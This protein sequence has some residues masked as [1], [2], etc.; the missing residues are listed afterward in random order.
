MKRVPLVR[1]TPLSPISK[2][3]KIAK[4]EY[5]KLK[6]IYLYSHELCEICMKNKSNQIHHRR[7]RGK[8]LRDVT[9]FMALCQTCHSMVHANPETSYLEGWLIK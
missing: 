4:N 5:M 7:H 1:K 2:K 9:T 8:Y 3:M 6:K